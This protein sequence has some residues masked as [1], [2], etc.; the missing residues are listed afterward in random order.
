MTVDQHSAAQNN[1]N[2]LV[3]FLPMLST[4]VPIADDR[5]KAGALCS[6]MCCLLFVPFIIAAI[7]LS[8]C[9][10]KIN[11]SLNESTTAVIIDASR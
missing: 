5:G 11:R 3:L 9:S 10:L 1:F 8:N 2:K 6:C 4:G 7:L